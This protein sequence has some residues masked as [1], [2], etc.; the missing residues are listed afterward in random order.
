MPALYLTLL[1]DVEALLKQEMS[2]KCLELQN[3]TKMIHLEA[4]PAWFLDL[5]LDLMAV[6][7]AALDL[8]MVPAWFLR[9]ED[10]E[11]LGEPPAWFLTL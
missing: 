7:L 2:G 9:I 4:L 11:A 8:W 10:V 5:D 6:L 1:L 3:L